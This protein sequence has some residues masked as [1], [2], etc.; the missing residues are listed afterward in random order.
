MIT[1]R[2]RKLVQV[3]ATLDPKLGGPVA[4][5]EGINEFLEKEF[6]HILLVFGSSQLL[7][8]NVIQEKT[9]FQNRYGVLTRLF[10]AKFRDS[11]VSAD[12]ILLH[13][14]YLYSTLFALFFA[15]TELIYI[16][17]HGSLENYQSKNGKFRKKIFEFFFHRFLNN[18][19]F[20]FLVGSEPEVIS[21]K[22]KFP[23]MD[24]KVVGIGVNFYPNIQKQIIVENQPIYLYCMSR[25]A[26]KK[27]L[28]LCIQALSYLNDSEYDFRLSIYGPSGGPLEEEL[29]VLTENLHLS[30]KVEFKGFVS[31]GNN[32]ES[33]I[34]DSHILL[35]PS[36]NEN[37]AVAVA[38]SI[39]NLRPVLVSN[40]VAM[41]EFVDV[42]DV[43]VTIDIL[44]AAEIA[45]GVL[46]IV[47]DFEK[48]S[49]NCF[50]SRNFLTWTFVSKLWLNELNNGGF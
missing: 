41:H 25:I 6:D 38:E 20:T 48:Y 15:R 2:P 19:R 39:G 27:R 35:L 21:V 24:V 9:L 1:G 11:L 17:P 37:F 44:S 32:K 12:L 29:R 34:K 10:S 28:D 8:N 26:A 45:S 30:K 36:E 13:G 3:S 49:E 47:Q 50:N 23:N 46:R 4:V 43:G 42:H 16:M 7:T 5:V 18:R 33:A 40:F 14:F 22:H 31:E